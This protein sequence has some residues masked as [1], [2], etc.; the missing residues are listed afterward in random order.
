VTAAALAGKSLVI[1]GGTTGLGLSA[2]RAFL[3]AGARGV[4]V[5]GRNH[6][7]AE[8]AVQQLGASGFAHVGDATEPTHAAKAIVLARE[9]F[10][11]FD[12]LYHV[13]GGS[14]R[15][16]GD[17]PLHDVTDEGVRATLDLNLHSVIY[18]NRAAVQDFLAHRTAGA[19]LNIGSVLGWSPSPHFFATHVY[20]A[21]KSAVVGFTKSIAAYY[22]SQGIRA[23]VLAPALVET[24]MARRAAND[25]TILKFI[26]TK[27]PLDGGR[28]GQPDDCDGAAVYFL[29][30]AARFVTGQ[31]LA[32]D[33]GWSVSEGQIPSQSPP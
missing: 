3:A 16:F 28:I 10:G 32:V 12:A 1:I 27:Q 19:I 2:A 23:N 29:S 30:D 18:S 22:A 5:T 26:A 15:K 17:G 25:A 8:A 9:R 21:A 24:P 14:G 13:A 7:S 33:G 4:V 20:A 11:G 6:T 31:V